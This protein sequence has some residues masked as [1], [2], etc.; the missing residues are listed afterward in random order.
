VGATVYLTAN[1]M[2]QR[3]DGMSGGGFISSSDQRAHF[4]LGD[5]ADAGSAD[6]HRPSG[7]EEK[8]ALPALDRIY[9]VTEGKGITGSLCKGRPCG[10]ASTV[11]RK[12]V[13]AVD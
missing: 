8:I 12:P 3:E 5:A 9:T 7:A 1:G 13:A 2:S 6:I 10:V 11:A 4:G